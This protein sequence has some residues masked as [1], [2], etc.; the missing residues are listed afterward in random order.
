MITPNLQDR[1]VAVTGARTTYGIG[2]AIAWDFTA[3]GARIT[4]LV[5][6]VRASS[7]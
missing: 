2:A 7:V 1:V 4:L 5:G 6:D 3:Q